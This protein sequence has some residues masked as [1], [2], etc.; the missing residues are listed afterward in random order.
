MTTSSDLIAAYEAELAEQGKRAQDEKA[1]VQGRMAYYLESGLIT[2]FE[3]AAAEFVPHPKKSSVISYTSS[4]YDYAAQLQGVF[5]WQGL[6]L[7]IRT[8]AR[9][10]KTK[11]GTRGV[12]EPVVLICEFP[13]ETL[14]GK[15]MYSKQ[16]SVELPADASD[17]EGWTFFR[18]ARNIDKG[19]LGRFFWDVTNFAIERQ[20]QRDEAREE[21]I[22]LE[23]RMLNVSLYDVGSPDEL[24]EK[25]KLAIATY[26]EHRDDF[27]KTQDSRL[28]MLT[29]YAKEKARHEA[30]VEQAM[31]WIVAWKSVLDANRKLLAQLQE[32]YARPITCRILYYGVVAEEEGEKYA[33][34]QSLYVREAY[35]PDDLWHVYYQNSGLRRERVFHPVRLAEEDFEF[36]H[37]PHDVK[38]S[39]Y[40]QYCLKDLL[41]CVDDVDAALSDLAELPLSDLPVAPDAW[42]WDVISAALARSGLE[43]SGVEYNE[44]LSAG[45][46]DE[47][48]F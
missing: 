11:S 1:W 8:I 6:D 22:E 7:V 30:Q 19:L 21:E 31:D 3:G 17:E 2:W 44:I 46:N 38:S 15:V 16:F 28:A 14:F 35:S 42:P 18:A 10:G 43:L 37:A 34:V 24:R 36:A 25:V 32:Q 23:S 20:R 48:V 45:A 40:V 27:L 5:E 39:T 33:A 13:Q 26:P 41:Y 12:T 47:E 9:N 29:E 4:N